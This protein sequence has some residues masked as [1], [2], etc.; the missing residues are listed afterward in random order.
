[1][2]TCT[3][4]KQEKPMKEFSWDKSQRD[5]HYPQCK[6]CVREYGRRRYQKSDKEQ[7][8]K[9][10]K[11]YYLKNK[12][13]ICKRIREKR[14]Q[15]S[16]EQQHSRD[17]K[18]TLRVHKITPE[19]YDQMLAEQNGR[20]AICGVHQ[21]KFKS[22]L[23]V[24]HNHKTGENRGLLCVRCNVRLGVVENRGFI[25]KATAYLERWRS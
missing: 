12:E 24:D 7:R 18:R 19:Q 20:C 22:T 10:D 8:R 2:K 23:A 3:K 9:Q 15:M 5:G 16:G 17:R 13:Q 6:T 4:C 14:A 21:S 1:M 25:R 11:R